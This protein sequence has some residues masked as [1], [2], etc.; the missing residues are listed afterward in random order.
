MKSRKLPERAC[1]SCG[2]TFQPT[3]TWHAFCSHSCRDDANR[4]NRLAE[5]ACEYCGLVADTID[6]VPPVSVRPTLIELD[7]A[8]KIPFVEVRCCKE[9]NCLLGRKPLWTIKQRRDY[10]HNIL[11]IRYAKYLAIPEWIEQDLNQLSPQLREFTIHGIAIRE[12]V[13]QRLRRSA[14]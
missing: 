9:C 2:K 10:I 1:T 7:L 5:Y 4:E 6:H 12:V 8:F 13:K 11:K 14:R 3:R